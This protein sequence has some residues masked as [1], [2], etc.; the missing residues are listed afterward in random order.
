MGVR[1]GPG[2]GEG[3][4]HWVTPDPHRVARCACG[5]VTRVPPGDRYCIPRDEHGNGRCYC[6]GCPHYVPLPE[7]DWR[8]QKANL[9]EKARQKNERKWG[10]R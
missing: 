1:R 4:L 2:C 10:K 5:T 3:G 8:R 9:A 7:I 6:G